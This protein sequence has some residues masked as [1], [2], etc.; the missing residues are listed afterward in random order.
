MRLALLLSGLMGLS[1]AVAQETPLVD[2]TPNKVEFA[3]DL[4]D[5]VVKAS[6]PKMAVSAIR[7]GGFDFAKLLGMLLFDYTRY[8]CT[9]TVGSAQQLIIDI[10]TAV[11]NGG[12]GDTIQHTLKAYNPA[13]AVAARKVGAELYTVNGVPAIINELDELGYTQRIASNIGSEEVKALAEKYTELF[14]KFKEGKTV[15]YTEGVPSTKKP[16]PK[17]FEE[18]NTTYNADSAKAIIFIDDQLKNINGA[19]QVE[20]FMP[21]KFDNAQQ[22]R[23]DLKAL[24]IPLR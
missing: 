16:S 14:A 17:Y 22:L 5:V 12:T 1:L 3:W 7:H 23:A 24:G 9:G 20:P 15:T 8:A 4:H 21:V 19:R 10:K 11:K 13:L 6:Y 18:Y 2:A